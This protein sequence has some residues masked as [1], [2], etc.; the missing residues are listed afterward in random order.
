MKGSLLAMAISS[1]W[2]RYR[3]RAYWAWDAP[4][5]DCVG[6]DVAYYAPLFLTVRP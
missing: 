4:G 2:W 6:P 1:R 5:P 3:G